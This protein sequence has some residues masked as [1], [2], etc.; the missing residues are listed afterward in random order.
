[1]SDAN[2]NND[3]LKTSDA[4]TA[5]LEDR[6]RDPAMRALYQMSRTAG[7]GLQDYAA[8]NN[9]A[10]IGLLCGAS[11]AL[12]YLL[13]WEIPVYPLVA[14]AGLVLGIVS[15]VQITR[16]NGT[17]TGTLL[18]I[19]AIVLSLGVGAW[20]GTRGAMIAAE[21]KRHRAAI[22]EVIAAFGDQI[23]QGNFT[24]SYAATDEAFRKRVSAADFEA[25]LSFVRTFQGMSLETFH[26][27]PETTQII[28]DINGNVSAFTLVYLTFKD[29]QGQSK[30]LGEVEA[31][32]FPY[33]GKWKLHDI[34]GFF[35]PPPKTGQR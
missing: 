2:A 6:R 13:L 5:A 29:A 27:K 25:K 3:A 22:G 33:D 16:S 12:L 32:L 1:M 18:A 21:D 26:A 11:A 14:A 19:G 23:R 31:T 17:Q 34:P 35:A 30:Q 7:V 8:I 24:D 4:S 28:R 9:L 20:A 15:L 10:V